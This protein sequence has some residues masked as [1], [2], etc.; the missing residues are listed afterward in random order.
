MLRGPVIP[1]HP[2]GV[3]QVKSSEGGSHEQGRRH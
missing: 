1:S 2:A 3:L